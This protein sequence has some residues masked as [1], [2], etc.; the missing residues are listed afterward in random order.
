V[1]APTSTPATSDESPK[2]IGR[3]EI[4][5]FLGEGGFG[6]VYEAYD[7]SL[8]RAVA[9]K[10]AKPEQVQTRERVER[11]LRE[12]QSAGR[13]MHPHIVAVFDSGK[14]EQQ[15]YIASAFVRGRSLDRVVQENEKGLDA[16]RVAG[17]VRKLA[18]ALAY[19]HH[20]GV[21][22]RDVKPGNVMLREDGEPMLMDFGLAARQEA[23]EERLTQ[24]LV[25]MGTPA[26]MAPEQGKGD[27]VAA[28]DQYSLGVALFELMTGHLP[29]AGGS[30]AHLLV[31]HEMQPPPSPRTYRPDVPRDL[32]AICLKCLEKDP[33]KRYP[34]CQELADDLRRWADGEPVRARL[35]GP[36]ERAA[37]WARRRPAAAALLV[38]SAVAA[39][40]LLI[41]GLKYSADL[42]GKN[43]E[44]A[45]ALEE[46]KT[47][48]DAAGQAKVK[49]QAAREAAEKQRELTRQELER[50][51]R[52]LYDV[53]L[54]TI[55]ATW[56]A[57]PSHAQLLLEDPERFPPA[58]RES[59]WG[60][61]HSLCR[62]SCQVFPAHPQAGHALAFSPDGKLFA[63]GGSD[64]MV[65]LW[66]A[67]TN[68]ELAV[69]KGHTNDIWAL[70]FSADGSRLASTAGSDTKVWDVRGRAAIFHAPGGSGLS[71][72]LSPDGKW[73]AS[74]G[75]PTTVIREVG[76]NKAFE[77]QGPKE[78]PETFSLAFSPDGKQLAVAQGCGSR[79]A[80]PS[81]GTW[82]RRSSCTP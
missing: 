66:D 79:R 77:L 61:Y 18:E 45:D 76:S 1:T 9:L 64:G 44:L 32:E 19:A 23:G 7:P 25:T 26:Y 27:A 39:L 57:D 51:R 14:D 46:V 21:V 4:R 28:S 60:F 65:R 20:E 67:A 34:D 11:F 40:S 52:S 73:V 68:R 17:L 53:Q 38:V 71:V 41:G 30:P 36:L 48:R 42:G 5:Q 10:V 22:H 35:P 69:L 2:R 50:V 78:W 16:Q 74:A 56:E 55:S 31:L 63:T 59:V 49:E 13:L 29:F 54:Q 82:P 8:K 47:E 72:A 24:G 37:R 15:Y 62:R 33:R 58:L 80:G 3:F 12:A 75:G 70:S 6:R 81:S 43:Q